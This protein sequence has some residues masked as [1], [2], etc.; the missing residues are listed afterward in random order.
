MEKKNNNKNKNW[1]VFISHKRIQQEE[2]KASKS[3]KIFAPFISGEM[4]SDE[5]GNAIKGTEEGLTGL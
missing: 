1:I 3:R 4:N 5:K 2:Q